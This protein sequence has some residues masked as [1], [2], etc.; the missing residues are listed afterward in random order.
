MI[1]PV[2]GMNHS[3]VKLNRYLIRHLPSSL[4]SRDRL[5]TVEWDA[6]RFSSRHDHATLSD[7]CGR[8]QLSLPLEELENLFQAVAM[9]DHG[10]RYNIAPTQKV[11]IVRAWAGK[12]EIIPLNW[13]LV[14]HWAQDRTKAARMINARSETVAE[15]PSFRDSFRHQRCLVPATGFY[16]WR[17]ENAS[18]TPY[19]IQIQGAPAYAMAGIWSRWMSPEGPFES[20]S[21]LTTEAAPTIRDI[22]ERMP[23]ILHPDTYGTWLDP[24]A[25]KN[26]LLSLCTAV[27]DEFLSVAAVSDHV[28]SARNDDPDCEAPALVQESLL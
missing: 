15:K 14:P 11:P 19:L 22:H 5:G 28:N 12:R 9:G 7:M 25:H 23:V 1:V 8:Y 27:P 26:H 3:M 21:I 16:E 6:D 4:G 18:K 10:P 20:Y 13:G 17:R 24:A 2:H